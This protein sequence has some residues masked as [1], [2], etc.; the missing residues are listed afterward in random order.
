MSENKVLAI[1]AGEEI[2][3]EM[4]D[5]ILA[6]APRE[7]QQY[8]NHPQMRQQYLDQL[9]NMR[10]FSQLG[11]ELKLEETEEFQKILES[12]KKDIL[13]QLAMSEVLGTL[14]ITEEESKAYFEENA[15]RY[16]KA[17]TVSA[18]HILVDDEDT[19]AA[20]KAK[21]DADEITFEDCAKENSTCPSKERGG[22]LGEF[23][24][25]QMVR[26]FEQAAFEAEV[27]QVVGPVKTQFGYHL[28]KVEKKNEA[29]IPAYEEVKASVE[30]EML[31]KKQDAV[32][33]ET[34]EEL[35]KKYY[36]TV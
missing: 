10:L 26:E 35:R 22:D 19:C 2:T 8:I 30:R 29:V 6:Q 1:V 28:I 20:L 3:E 18:K 23:G 34:V 31:Q 16:G 9:I 13:C 14:T 36:Q 24:K 7:H 25:G 27:G 4:L 5:S 15:S 32:Y 17:P 11:I 21:L 12:A 33:R